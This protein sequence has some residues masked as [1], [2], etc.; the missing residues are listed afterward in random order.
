MK[1]DGSGTRCKARLVAKGFMQR[2]VL[3]YTETYAPVAR[4]PT[5]RL[6]LALSNQFQLK[7]VHMDV[8][9]AFLHG[10]MDEEVYLAPPDGVQVPE[11]HALRLLKSLYG[12]RQSN[13]C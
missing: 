12:L 7:V 13:K 1:E 4:L 11:G 5:V 8:K 2:K 10:T 3:D 6:L 9:A